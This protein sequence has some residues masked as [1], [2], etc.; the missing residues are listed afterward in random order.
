MPIIKRAGQT[1]TSNTVQ[2][3]TGNAATSAVHIAEVTKQLGGNVAAL[4][5][6]YLN[7]S[8]QALSTAVYDLHM[9]KATEEFNTLAQE[10]ISKTTDDEGNPNFATLPQDIEKIGNDV[11]MKRMGTMFDPNAA[12]QFSRDF[13]NFTS[14]QS[15][16]AAN[17]SRQQELDYNRAQVKSTVSATINKSLTVDITEVEGPLADMRRSLDSYLQSGAISKQEYDQ[18]LDSTRATVYKAKWSEIIAQ[19]ADLAREQ[20]S[21]E[22]VLGLTEVERRQMLGQAEAKI[23][24]NKLLQEKILK[25]NEA[26]IKKKSRTNYTEWDIG[27]EKGT[28]GLSDLEALSNSGSIEREDYLAGLKRYREHSKNS[29]LKVERRGIISNLTAIDN[30]QEIPPELSKEANDM[31]KEDVA[32]IE[33]ATET[34]MTYEQLAGKAKLY[35][36]PNSYIKDLLVQATV[37]GGIQGKGDAVNAYSYLVTNNPLSLKELPDNVRT[38][39]EKA[40]LMSSNGAITGSEAL[41]KLIDIEER[42]KSPE[43]SVVMQAFKDKMTDS[44]VTNSTITEYINDK[45]ESRGDLPFFGWNKDIDPGLMARIQESVRDIAISNRSTDINVE[46]LVGTALDKI[47][48]LGYNEVGA[49]KKIM[50]LAPVKVL[51]KGIDTIQTKLD[52]DIQTWIDIDPSLEGLTSDNVFLFATPDTLPKK[53]E[54]RNF[55][56]DA[57]SFNEQGELVELPFVFSTS[58]EELNEIEVQK[59]VEKGERDL[60]IAQS[61]MTTTSITEGEGVAAVQRA[62]NKAVRKAQDIAR[63]GIESIPEE[64]SIL[65]HGPLAPAKFIFDRLMNDEDK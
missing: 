62:Q 14:S 10:R 28:Q 29:A 59:A 30:P 12:S 60:E 27:L 25:E 20:L 51:G 3:G 42:S 48:H 63:K 46:A 16:K 1:G 15:I 53:G 31:F 43:A 35:R 4:G 44:K 55:T 5:K 8:Q 26:N 61:I 34:P 13:R 33:K 64:V 39:Y 37:T 32:L 9:Q 65:K 56:W 36:T 19:D 49:N 17:V 50:E 40:R 21:Q 47:E 57:W 54:D 18:Q 52:R 22:Q 45:L 7:K 6:E 38:M 23:V 58:V 41:K 24:D 2:I 11:M